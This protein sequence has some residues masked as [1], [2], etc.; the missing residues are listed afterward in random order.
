MISAINFPTI[1]FILLFVTTVQLGGDERY[2]YTL[3]AVVFLCLFRLFLLRRFHT[4]Q[5][6]TLVTLWGVLL[7]YYPINPSALLLQL[8]Y[9]TYLIPVMIIP[10]MSAPEKIQAAVIHAAFFSLV[11]G[12]VA[13]SIGFGGSSTYG[14]TRLQGLMSEPS[15]MALPISI[16]LLYGLIFKNI[17]YIFIGAICCIL[18][19]SIMVYVVIIS[20]T[21]LVL[22][23]SRNPSARTV[24]IIT[25]VVVCALIYYLVNLY[26]GDNWNLGRAQAGLSSLFTLGAEGYNPR[27]R[28]TMEVIEYRLL[29]GEFQVFFGSG[30]NSS[31][32]YAEETS[33]FRILPFS[34]EL[35]YSFG[36]FGIIFYLYA[37]RTVFSIRSKLYACAFVPTFIY[38]SVNSAQG[39]SLGLIFIILIISAARSVGYVR[40][41]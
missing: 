3:P 17:Y 24:G 34:G 35:I 12:L 19:H 16:V 9:V 8:K 5:I 15:A 21:I 37:L 31:A 38:V 27:V 1:I 7:L 36:V 11:I 29:S 6:I 4:G 23:S 10:W 32:A 39:I 41:R 30:I 14:I 33:G 28:M 25:S 20:S 26:V 40:T 18:T 22:I 2:L 13:F